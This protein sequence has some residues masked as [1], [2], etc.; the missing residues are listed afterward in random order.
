MNITAGVFVH[1]VICI[2]RQGVETRHIFS[3]AEKAL[4]F[5]N[6]DRARN[7]VFYDYLLDTPERH[8]GL[9]Q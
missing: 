3:T 8:E 5:A 1:V 6:Q 2:D 4:E 7:H 9:T